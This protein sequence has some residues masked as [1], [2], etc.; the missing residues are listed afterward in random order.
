MKIDRIAWEKTKKKSLF[1]AWPMAISGVLMPFVVSVAVDASPA[2]W[3]LTP[4]L[5]LLIFVPFVI[6][7]VRRHNAESARE[8]REL[9]ARYDAEDKAMFGKPLRELEI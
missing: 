3:L 5:S 7:D 8:E 6:V 1:Y 9:Q 2:F 4:W